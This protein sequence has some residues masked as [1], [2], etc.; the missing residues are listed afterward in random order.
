[1]KKALSMGV[2]VFLLFTLFA[3]SE[4][5][6]A[7]SGES[8]DPSSKDHPIVGAWFFPEEDV[9]LSFHN[10]RAIDFFYF[11]S[12]AY[13]WESAGSY[14]ING[15]TLQVEFSNG[16]SLQPLAYSISGDTL[17][18]RN[19]ENTSDFVIGERVSDTTTKLDNI[20]GTWEKVSADAEGGFY[21]F[22]CFSILDIVGYVK[23]FTFFKD[24]SYT[25]ENCQ[26][27][28][29]EKFESAIGRFD[30]KYELVH[31]SKTILFDNRNYFDYSLLENG[32]L[33]LKIPSG[34]TYIYA[35]Q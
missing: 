16:E 7:S 9:L 2:V 5:S 29:S 24:A 18:L 11:E 26:Y 3:C 22:D 6:G 35:H 30:G 31:N 34:P 21:D 4:S 8:S 10:D 13:D 28:R 25:T 33:L 17:T 14:V 27:D 15:N 20:N 12:G 1:M 23:R 19:P 32:L